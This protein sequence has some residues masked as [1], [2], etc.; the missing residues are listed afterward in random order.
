MAMNPIVSLALAS[1][2]FVGTHL[3]LSH[4][5]RASLV[6]RLGERGFAGIYSLI[7]LATFAWMIFAWRAGSDADAFWVAPLWWWPFASL[8]M[9]IAS[10]LLVG[11]LI[12]NPA[13]PKPGVAPRPIPPPRGVFAI[14]RHPMNW[15]FLLWALVHASISGSRRNLIVAAGIAVLALF[16]SIGQD[17]KKERLLGDIWRDWEARTS[18]VP[19]GA[20]LA[21]KVR[22]RDAIPGAVAL[23]GGL[24]FWALATSYHAPL[25]S[26]LGDLLSR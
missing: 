5:L 23:I 7:A 6:A 4:P 8:L 26:P 11:A 17:R 22:W 19:F 24:V 10:I 20:L 14:T 16:G 1:V 15:S 21:G 18:F 3:L 13:F 12:G 25:V 9:A 2:A